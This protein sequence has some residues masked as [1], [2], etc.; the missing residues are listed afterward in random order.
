MNAIVRIDDY[1]FAPALLTGE[2]VLAMTRDGVLPEGRG[3]ELIEGVLVKMAAQHDPHVKMIGQLLRRL[4]IMLPEECF[5]ASAPSIFLSENTMLEPDIAIY[6]L[7]MKSTD[8][9]GPDLALVI[10]VSDT[11][12]RNDLGKK[13]ALYAAH[14]V[15]DYWVVDVTGERLHRHSGPGANGYADIS[16]NGPGEAVSLPPTG[17]DIHIFG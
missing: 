16:I 7:S 3:Y 12:L 13:A 14:G 8:V 6:P 10:E 2:D 5:V 17:A 9:R 4:N 11:T 15:R 1:D